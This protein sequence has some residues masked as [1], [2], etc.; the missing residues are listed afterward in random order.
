MSYLDETVMNVAQELADDELYNY[1]VLVKLLGDGSTLHLGFLLPGLGSMVVC[2]ATMRMRMPTLMLFPELW[3][4]TEL[5]G[6][7]S[8]TH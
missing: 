2:D 5:A 8:R 3:I 7:P 1:D 6:V 4:S